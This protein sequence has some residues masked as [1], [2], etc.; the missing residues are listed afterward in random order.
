M[1]WSEQANGQRGTIEVVADRVSSGSPPPPPPAAFAAR[2]DLDV[3]FAEKDEAKRLGAWWD[4][5]RRCWYVPPG[6]DPA[7]FARWRVDGLTTPAGV[8]ALPGRC[9]RC[10]APTRAIVGILVDPELGEG[11]EDGFVQFDEDIARAI[12]RQLSINRLADL[13]I[14]PLRHRWSGTLQRRYLSNGCAACDALLGNFPLWE[15]LVEFLHGGGTYDALVV[16]EVEILE[17]ILPARRR[18]RE[19][20]DETG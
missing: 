13:G 6:A 17:A 1:R 14:G 7:L 15:A 2:V 3:P 18:E 20:I 5:Y 9:W 4:P 10:K 11:D 16:D 8:V 12:S 19:E